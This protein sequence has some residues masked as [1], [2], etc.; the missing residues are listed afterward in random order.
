M[1]ADIDGKI[2]GLYWTEKCLTWETYI[3]TMWAG[4]VLQFKLPPMDSIHILTGKVQ[5]FPPAY[6]SKPRCHTQ[7]QNE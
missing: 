1:M 4:K 2:E 5:D 7:P 6:P 3:D